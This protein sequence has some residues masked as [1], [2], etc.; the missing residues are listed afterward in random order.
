MM[1]LVGHH[2]E[3]VEPLFVRRLGQSGE[4]GCQRSGGDESACRLYEL[5]S[6]ELSHYTH[7]IG[8]SVIVQP[9]AC[10]VKADSQLASFVVCW[11]PC[12]AAR[13]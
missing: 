10:I 1:M 12:N 9:R 2:E 13:V 3:D 7:L 8:I 5:S 6:G 4:L 11:R